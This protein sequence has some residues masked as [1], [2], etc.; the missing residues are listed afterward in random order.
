MIHK[1]THIPLM[2]I[3]VIVILSFTACSPYPPLA[4]ASDEKQVVEI[5]DLFQTGHSR[6]QE[7]LDQDST[8]NNAWLSL[9]EQT[10]MVFIDIEYDDGE[11]EQAQQ[12]GIILNGGK[13][14]LTVGHCLVIDDGKILAIRIRTI[15]GTEIPVLLNSLIY[16]NESKPVVD[17]AILRPP[18]SFQYSEPIPLPKVDNKSQL[19]IMGYPGGMGVNKNGGVVRVREEEFGRHYPLGIV[20]EQHRVDRHLLLPRA[21]AIPLRGISGAPIFNVE[22]ELIGLFSS[23]GRRRILTGW[24]YIFNTV[25]IPWITINEIA[26]K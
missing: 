5:S 21:G 24:E 10:V 23:I 2:L 19:L 17:W 6:F 18:N 11:K 1:S 25:D 4:V 9:R 26:G 12:S 3:L 14:V 7:A 8:L 16:D 13:I 20:S 22:G 15:A